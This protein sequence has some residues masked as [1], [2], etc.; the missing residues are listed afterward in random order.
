M[1][2]VST[3]TVLL[4]AN[5]LSKITLAYAALVYGGIRIPY[6]NGAEMGLIIAS[7]PHTRR[8]IAA[9]IVLSRFIRN[10][11]KVTNIDDP[12]TLDPLG[13]IGLFYY[14]RGHA[15]YA[16]NS[17]SLLYYIVETGN[18]KDPFTNTEFSSDEL[19]RLDHCTQFHKLVYVKHMSG[20]LK[21]RQRE[22]MIFHDYVA[23]VEASI[24]SIVGDLDTQIT[25][26]VAHPLCPS[27][28]NA[29]WVLLDEFTSVCLH[30]RQAPTA[31]DAGL[32]RVWQRILH[33]PHNTINPPESVAMLQLVRG[34]LNLIRCYVFNTDPTDL[35]VS[36]SGYAN[37][38]PPAQRV[39]L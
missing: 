10:H 9:V 38:F 34:R 20:W 13:Q 17:E 37:V 28:R 32:N 24:E 3:R 39:L 30:A 1:E 29:L 22:V 25:A 7:N 19:A 2:R 31:V 23:A 18:I 33:A 14:T 11:V 6:K 36:L 35:L 12:F 4:H 8:I 21:K 26:F 5:N 16:C 15:R 27:T